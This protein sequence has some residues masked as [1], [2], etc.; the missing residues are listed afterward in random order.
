MKNSYHGMK[1]LNF[2]V[3]QRADTLHFGGQFDIIKLMIWFSSDQELVS[4]KKIINLEFLLG[5]MWKLLSE[6]KL[7]GLQRENGGIERTI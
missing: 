6:P 2:S 7:I 1:I 4:R 5:K 3:D